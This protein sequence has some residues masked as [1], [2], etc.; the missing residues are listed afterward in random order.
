MRRRRRARA[1]AGP[2][3][4]VAAERLPVER[5]PLRFVELSCR[6][7]DCSC[8][9]VSWAMVMISLALIC[10]GGQFLSQSLTGCPLLDLEIRVLALR[11]FQCRTPLLLWSVGSCLQAVIVWRREPV[12]FGKLTGSGL[13]IHSSTHVLG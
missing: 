9:W 6:H 10:I 1:A 4:V 13:V 8:E 12:E 7:R 5:R 11:I 3:P 2:N